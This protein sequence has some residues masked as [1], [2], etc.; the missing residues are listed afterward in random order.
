MS[1]AMSFV[2]RV[3]AGE[4]EMTGQ[5]LAT[6]LANLKNLGWFKIESTADGSTLLLRSR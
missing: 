6:E 2:Q 1:P 3:P 4:M 5:L